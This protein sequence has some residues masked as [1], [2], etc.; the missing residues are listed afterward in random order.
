MNNFF[1]SN[2]EANVE[3]GPGVSPETF[4]PSII[5]KF[6]NGTVSQMEG[7]WFSKCASCLSAAHIHFG[8]VPEFHGLR[9]GRF[10]NVALA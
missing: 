8:H 10:Q 6:E 1:L 5:L 3:G 9:A 7:G 2:P 4:S